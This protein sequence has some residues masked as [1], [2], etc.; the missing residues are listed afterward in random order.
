MGKPLESPIPCLHIVVFFVFII[1]VIIPR[2]L[3]LRV[4]CLRIK[5]ARFPS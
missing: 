3:S 2:A 1:I 4:K 5:S